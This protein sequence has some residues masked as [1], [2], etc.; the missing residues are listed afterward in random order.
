M[1]NAPHSS[2]PRAPNA[3]AP[4]GAAF[5]ETI[6]ATDVVRARSVYQGDGAPPSP[7]ASL[8]ETLRALPIGIQGMWLGI[9]CIVL[10]VGS[11]A[12]LRSLFEGNVGAAVAGPAPSASSS[13][14]PAPGA[15]STVPALGSAPTATAAPT[16]TSVSIGGNNGAPG[17]MGGFGAL[18]IRDRL[19][20][21]I[22]LRKIGPFLDDLDRLLEIEPS[23]ID[24]ADLRKMIADA[25]MFAMVPGLGGAL[26]PEAERIFTF[27][28]TRA[29][30]A[31]PDIL[32]E[33]V[34]TRGGT[35]AA[36]HADE[37]LRR[38]DVRAKGTPALR[39][40]WEMRAATTCDARVAL[41]GRA[42]AEGDRRVL[43]TLFQMTKCGRG[44]TDCCLSSDPAYKEVLQAI[45]S[46]K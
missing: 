10:L 32:F 13:A 18:A 22:R 8:A 21:S 28:T 11:A 15:A 43:A 14:T 1:A 33:L 36:A 42:K 5:S 19:T 41:F 31:G 4:A 25:A 17:G 16:A 9:V 27:L 24:R 38:E 12:A 3:P 40:A 26:Q 20:T 46:K 37:L 30:T 45:T 44:P 35:R 2:D 6:L 34:T 7:P 23:A 39:V 29:G